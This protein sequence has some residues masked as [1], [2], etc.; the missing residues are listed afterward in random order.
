MFT[1]MLG[2]DGQPRAELFLPDMLH[3]TEAGYRIWQSVVA[4]F[5]LPPDA[6]SPPPR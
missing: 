1:P 6:L 3:M 2:V 5:L 4:P